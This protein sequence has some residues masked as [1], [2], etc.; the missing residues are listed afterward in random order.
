MKEPPRGMRAKSR[1]CGNPGSLVKKKKIGREKSGKE[2]WF[3]LESWTAL[4]L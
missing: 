3:S 2:E 4:N 1:E